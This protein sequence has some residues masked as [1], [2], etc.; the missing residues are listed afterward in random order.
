LDGPVVLEIEKAVVLIE[1]A[2]ASLSLEIVYCA[3]F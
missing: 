3:D 2:E 1:R